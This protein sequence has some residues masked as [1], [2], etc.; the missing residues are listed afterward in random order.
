M[1]RLAASCSADMT[2][3]DDWRLD[4]PAALKAGDAFLRPLAEAASRV[5]RETALATDAVASLTGEQRP[6]ALI[7]VGAEARLLRALLEPVCPV[8]V[9]AWPGVGLPGWVGPLDLVVV[10]GGTGHFAGA[11][12]HEAL[13]RGSR[14]LVV[15]PADSRL[16]RDSAARATTLL[17]T[18]AS[19]DPFPG[20][21]VALSAL[22]A[23][24]LGPAVD[25]LEVASALDD[26]AEDCGHR[27][28]MT[29]NP[30]KVLALDVAETQPLI[31]G[32][33]VVAARVSRRVAEALREASGGMALA[34]DASELQPLLDETPRRD[35]FADPDQGAE[36]TRPSLVIIDDGMADDE[37]EESAERLRRSAEVH[38]VRVSVLG[39]NQGDDLT[40]YA[41]LLAQGRFA[42]AYLRIGL[43]RV[44]P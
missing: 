20:A 25:P 9:V 21:V 33:S 4:D 31:W 38:D 28:D 12:L 35:P 44:T 7:A 8:P 22:H 16:A 5:R 15:A 43:G 23:F 14:I 34:A 19:T 40:R 11:G 24:G 42:A 2:T 27:R 36:G 13:R 10:L 6:R 17:P 37:T 41:T 26:V 29:Q 3:F 1:T 39:A 18:T 32:G 30:A